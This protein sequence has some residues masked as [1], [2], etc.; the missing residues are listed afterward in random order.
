MESDPKRAQGFLLRL[1][2]S[3]REQVTE[4]AHAEG[5]SVNHFICIALAEK[6][7]RM[8][9]KMAQQPEFIHHGKYNA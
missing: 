8:E 6:I 5:A 7:S 1:P 3:L 2:V 9:S 4:M